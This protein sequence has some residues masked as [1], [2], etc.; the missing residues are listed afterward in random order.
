MKP[1]WPKFQT[2]LMGV[3]LI[4]AGLGGWITVRSDIATLYSKAENL[5]HTVDGVQSTVTAILLMQRHGS[6]HAA[7]ENPDHH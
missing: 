1:N 4:V 5:Q 7:Y 6:D 3:A 2:Y